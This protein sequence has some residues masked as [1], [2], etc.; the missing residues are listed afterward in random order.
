VSRLF[1][2]D[3][4]GLERP[5]GSAGPAPDD[6]HH[7]ELLHRITELENEVAHLRAVLAGDHPGNE[8]V[9]GP[10]FV[11]G[12][13]RSGTWA[14]GR[15]IGQHPDVVTVRNELRFHVDGRGFRDVLNGSESISQFAARIEKSHYFFTGPN[16]GPRGLILIATR[17]ELRDA[18]RHAE[19]I[20]EYAGGAAGLRAFTHRL[21]D[22]FAFGRGART[23]VET[24]PRNVAAVDA[25]HEVF[26]TCRVIHSIRDGRDVAA[27]VVTMPWGPDA[28]EDGLA[29][30]AKRIRAADGRARRADPERLLLIR[31]EEL[32]HL[33][34]RGQFDRLVAFLGVDRT[35]ELQ[36]YFDQQ[37]T[38]D[39]AHVGRWRDASDVDRIAVDARYH[40]LY[41]ELVSEGVGCLPVAPDIADQ[42]ALNAS[43]AKRTTT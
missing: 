5:Q 14:L 37:M 6:G 1:R 29:W 7:G 38:A 36:T 39:R 35:D 33:D 19:L 27:S 9:A 42:I 25:L 24:T 13:G 31:L 20:A 30:W 18:T 26:P 34:R 17:D 16:S 32:L 40:S 3:S 21:V 2:R 11:G 12:T 41:D 8:P 22:P 15:L 28:V 4:A 43:A 10:I 23:W